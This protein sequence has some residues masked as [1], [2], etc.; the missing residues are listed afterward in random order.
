MMLSTTQTQQHENA[1]KLPIQKMKMKHPTENTEKPSAPFQPFLGT[2][3]NYYIV[4]TSL[5]QH[6]IFFLITN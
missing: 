4:Q 5:L 3:T 1:K 2:K 6:F